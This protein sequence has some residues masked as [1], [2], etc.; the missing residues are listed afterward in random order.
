MH[1]SPLLPEQIL[2][3]GK[4]PELNQTLFRGDH[5][6]HDRYQIYA[7]RT[8]ASTGLSFLLPQTWRL[9]IIPAGQAHFLIEPGSASQHGNPAHPWYLP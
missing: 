4:P 6:N 7:A 3:Q 1:P 8:P 9:Q 2:A 5:A